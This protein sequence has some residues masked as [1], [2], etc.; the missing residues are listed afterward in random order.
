MNFSNQEIPD[1]M[2]FYLALGSTFVPSK[3]HEKHDFVFDA[4]DF[5]RKLAWK[6]YY[7]DTYTEGNDNTP[8]SDP[9]DLSEHNEDQEVGSASGINGWKT[10]AKLKIKGRSYPE[11]NSKLLNQVSKRIISDVEGITLSN[12]KWKNLTYRTLWLKN[13]PEGS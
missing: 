8:L 10:P 4:K 12:K 13:V 2:Y 1:E 11:T 7:S 9:P 5:C 3:V 6:F